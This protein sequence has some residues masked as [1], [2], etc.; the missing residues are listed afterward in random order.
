MLFPPNSNVD[1]EKHISQEIQAE[2]PTDAQVVGHLYSSQKL[3]H[4]EEFIYISN[5][6]YNN[7]K[8]DTPF[9]T[10]DTS[11]SRLD[12]RIE[13]CGED[14]V[15]DEEGDETPPLTP[16]KKL[17]AEGCSVSLRDA[18][19]LCTTGSDSNSNNECI[20]TSS[21]GSPSTSPSW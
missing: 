12:E 16:M 17:P 18:R 4:E 21:L 10:P 3:Q 6:I 7:S 20:S 2:V 1:L 13:F 8:V 14:E 15:E 9:V 19:S 5:P 11:P